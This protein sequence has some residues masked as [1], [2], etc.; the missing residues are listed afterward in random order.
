M[1]RKKKSRVFEGVLA[2]AT[3][4][5]Y[6]WYL[7]IYQSIQIVDPNFLFFSV[8]LALLI[9]SLF[10]GRGFFYLVF[11]LSTISCWTYLNTEIVDQFMQR[12]SMM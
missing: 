2:S 11:S 8:L 7:F 4:L 5:G 6:Y 1:E 9:A 12:F 3:G 10:M